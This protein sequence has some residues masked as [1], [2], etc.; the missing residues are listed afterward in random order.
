MS[1]SASG[2]AVSAESS[3]G[4][5]PRTRVVVAIIVTLLAWASA[6][7]VIRY[8]GADFSGGGL[9]LGRLAVG[10]AVLG[11]L[12]IGKSWVRMSR[13]DWL[14]VVVIGLSWFGVYNVALNIAE[15]TLDAGTTAMIVN[16]GPILIALG[17]G[18]F[19]GEGIPRWL[20]I[21]ALVAFAGVA[22][23]GI[24]SGSQFIGNGV[25]IAWALLAAVT[26]AT[27]VLFQK[28]LLRRLPGI[29][30]TF[31]G[32][33][34]GAVA[35]L[36]FS[37]MLVRELATAPP[38]SIAG[39]VYLGA[40]PTAIAFSTW[41]YALTRMPAGRLGVTT[42]IVPALVILFGFLFLGEVPTALAIAGG[43]VC[44]VG[45]ALSR[46]TPRKGSVAATTAKDVASR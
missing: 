7:V 33:A 21:G 35:C 29:Q 16:I 30:I 36:P 20:V 19:L 15:Q 24:G 43:I 41:A 18:L 38:M 9:A 39:V 11:L 25:G 45:V 37:G 6:F 4:T 40:V 3:G 8:V 12:M 46:R 34:I 22:L 26:Y 13:R 42:Y 2:Q 31:L 1:T 32:C 23:I 28:P 14:I 10:T 27:G 17:A 44:L 5:E